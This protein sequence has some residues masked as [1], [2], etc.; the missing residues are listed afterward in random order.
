M[1]NC[2]NKLFFSHFLSCHITKYEKK[3]IFLFVVNEIIEKII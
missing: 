3:D 2:L 1:R